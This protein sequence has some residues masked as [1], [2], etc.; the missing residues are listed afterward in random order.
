M[1]AR[2][3][4]NGKGAMSTSNS[5]PDRPVP[6][7]P[8]PADAVADVGRVRALLIAAARRGRAVS[9][10]GLLDQL[11]HRFTRPRMRAL[12]R[13][14]D[15][16][17]AAGAAAGE[18]DLAVLVV[19]AAD[20]LPGQGWWVGGRPLREGY[21][22]PWLGSEALAFVGRLQERAFAHWAS[23]PTIVKSSGGCSAPGRSGAPRGRPHP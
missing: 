15:A 20:G 6:L 21:E 23:R 16:I 3:S 14:L 10:A 4:G 1:A 11:G 19:R 8:A 9:Y 2:N 12:C 5:C 22:G 17:D 7:D 18:P 13:T